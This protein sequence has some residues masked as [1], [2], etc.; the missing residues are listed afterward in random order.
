MPIHLIFVLMLLRSITNTDIEPLWQLNQANTPHVSGLSLD[1]FT[2]LLSIADYKVLFEHEDKIVGLLIGFLPGADYQSPNY[3]WFEQNYQ[4]HAY[5]DRI[6]ID[7]SA[8][9]LGI[10]S[11]LYQDFERFALE[12]KTEYLSCEVN[13][14][15]CN[16]VSLAFHEKQ[17]FE[18]AGTQETEGGQKEVALLI[19]PIQLG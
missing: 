8:R 12:H 17:G 10:A 4:A 1:E 18:Q 16:E 2:Q 11:R 6:A 15:P 13:I 14:R 3:Q 9:K 7:T 5:I 19:K